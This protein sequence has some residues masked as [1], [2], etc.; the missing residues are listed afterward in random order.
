M[1]MTHIHQ[2]VNSL[3][4]DVY[5]K[6]HNRGEEAIKR[7]QQ[8]GELVRG[9]EGKIERTSFKG[10]HYVE[11]YIIYNDVCV[12]RDYLDVPISHSFNSS[13]TSY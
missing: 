7:K 9:N 10:G 5:W 3:P 4:Y 13:I 1:E 12:A 6:V 11:C 2:G 8:R